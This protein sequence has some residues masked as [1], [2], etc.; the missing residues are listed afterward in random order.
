L[1]ESDKLFTIETEKMRAEIK[2]W[3]ADQYRELDKM[4]VA[5]QQLLDESKKTQQALQ[6]FVDRERPLADAIEARI[7]NLGD[8]KETERGKE[9]EFAYTEFLGV[10]GDTES[11]LDAYKTFVEKTDAVQT[12]LDGRSI[13]IQEVHDAS[14]AY[15]KE[16]R[17]EFDNQLELE[18]LTLE[19]KVD[20]LE[21]AYETQIKK[22]VEQL[23]AEKERI[24][25]ETVD[26]LK[27]QAQSFDPPRQVPEL[28]PMD[29]SQLEQ[30]V[31]HLE[32]KTV[33]EL[34][35][36]DPG[37]AKVQE[38][39][40]KA[41]G[42]AALFKKLHDEWRQKEL[43]REQRLQ[44][45]TQHFETTTEKLRGRLSEASA[46]EASARTSAEDAKLQYDVAKAELEE[47]QKNTGYKSPQETA[48]KK[49]LER[50][51]PQLEKQYEAEKARLT[52]ATA[53]KQSIEKLM[54][55]EKERNDAVQDDDYG[56][57]LV[58]PVMGDL[59]AIP[60][61]SKYV[62]LTGSQPPA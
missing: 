37:L 41:G 17:T 30:L 34:K 35:A 24:V 48:R 7:D 9:A 29:W 5:N 13:R 22:F 6:E 49:Y 33:E 57:I 36:D 1:D 53:N 39:Y 3:K 54:T 27:L 50:E 52:S 4:T 21:G 51:V 62:K 20:F 10:V 43:E 25:A 16:R 40:D 32:S 8:K 55:A 44:S 18:S 46:S 45:A 58:E 28:K 26:D 11:M 56:P 31:T 19:Q 12:A 47:F 2:D 23:K 59:A 60:L 61:R 42:D 14:E 38:A 15:L